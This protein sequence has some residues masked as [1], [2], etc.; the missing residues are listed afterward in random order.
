MWRVGET[1]ECLPIFLLHRK[2]HPVPNNRLPAFVSGLYKAVIGINGVFFRKALAQLL[3]PDDMLSSPTLDGLFEFIEAKKLLVGVHQ[4]C[5]GPPSHIR[6]SLHV[7]L[8]GTAAL[9]YSSNSSNISDLII[10]K[11]GFKHFAKA[12]I[13]LRTV[14]SLLTLLNAVHCKELGDV[15]GKGVPA[16]SELLLPNELPEMKLFLSLDLTQR[17]Q[18]LDTLLRAWLGPNLP[19]DLELFDLAVRISQIYGE[20]EQLRRCIDEVVTIPG[21]FS[22]TEER[23]LRSLECYV[24]MHQAFA[25]VAMC[26]KRRLAVS[27]G[28]GQPITDSFALGCRAICST[29]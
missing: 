25:A 26:L 7:M 13:N 12:Y 16:I 29:A 15:L 24:Q 21:H 6:E 28:F 20:D 5:A 8:N 1:A 11:D 4:V 14:G 9:R 2:S 18:L 3:S 23:I 27:L 10:D 19:A 17:E 22:S